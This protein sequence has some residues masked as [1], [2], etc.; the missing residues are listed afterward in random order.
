MLSKK[1]RYQGKRTYMSLVLIDSHM[2]ELNKNE[3]V[4]EFEY[5]LC[6]RESK[7]FGFDFPTVL[8]M[9]DSL[10][11][12]EEDD[13]EDGLYEAKESRMI[14]I[15]ADGMV[16]KYGERELASLLFSKMH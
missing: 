10:C 3:V 12:V 14:D 7:V 8:I 1:V 9:L 15:V 11:D 6:G 2:L 5:R 13:R 4:F 16:Y